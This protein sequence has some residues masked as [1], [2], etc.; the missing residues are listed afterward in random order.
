MRV[1]TKKSQASLT[2][3]SALQLLRDGN[4]RFRN[5][6]LTD[7]NL[8]EQIVETREGQW[9][10]AVILSCIDSRVSPAL[11]FDQG[12]GDVFSVRIAGN[13]VNEEILGSMEFGCIVAGAKLVVILGHRHCG[14]I[15]GACDNVQLG[16]LTK[17][18]ARL[19]PAV[20]QTTAPEELSLRNSG[21]DEFVQSVARNNVLLTM[22]Q[23]REQSPDLLGMLEAGKIDIV[24]A[25]YDVESGAVEFME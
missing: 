18:I 6:K 24:G 2:P 20:E 4:E 11:I 13:F 9:P 8:L 15:K 10:F 14:A 3:E 16:N 1:Q 7:R 12:L 17:L 21:N 5:G 19:K 25:M 23:V 22:L